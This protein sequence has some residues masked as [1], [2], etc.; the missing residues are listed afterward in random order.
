LS[1]LITAGKVQNLDALGKRSKNFVHFDKGGERLQIT[2]G[3][4]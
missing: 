2:E 3:N 4:K 1:V